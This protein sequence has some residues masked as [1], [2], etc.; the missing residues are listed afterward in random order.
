VY[1]LVCLLVYLLVYFLVYLLVY[2]L[3]YRLVYLLEWL[4]VH[5]ALQRHD[6]L[7]ADDSHAVCAHF[8]QYTT[9]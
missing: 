7:Y 3:V 2:L 9:R 8:S 1:L 4:L 5:F 6:T